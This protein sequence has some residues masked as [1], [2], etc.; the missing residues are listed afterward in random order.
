LRAAL[1]QG[2]V[3]PDELSKMDVPERVV[4]LGRTLS[5]FRALLDSA[6]LV[7]PQRAVRIA[8]QHHTVELPEELEFEG[9]LDWSP[10]RLHLAQALCARTRVRVLLPWSQAR[11]ELNA[12]LEPAFRALE[13][14]GAGPAPEVQL[15]DPAAGPLAPFVRQLFAD[16][17][18]P[19]EADVA[20][21]SCASPAAQAREVARRCAT[22]LS[23]G[24]APDSIAV[25]ARS[26]GEGVAEEIQAALDRASIAWRERRGRPALPAPPVQ[27]ALSLSRLLEEDFPREPLIE[28]LSSRQL[29]LRQDGEVLPPQALARRL[30]EAHCRDDEGGGGYAARLRRLRDRLQVKERRCEDIA[31]VTTRVERLIAQVRALPERATCKEHGAALLSLLGRCNLEP[32]L[33]AEEPADGGPALTRA[34]L[35]ALARDQAAFQ[36]LEECCV[37]VARAA[38]QLASSEKRIARAEWTQLLT[39]ILSDA[40]LAPGGARGGAVQLVELRELAGRS[41][42]HVL[43]VGLVDGDLPQ[44]AAADPLLSDD[45]KRAVNRAARRLVFRDRQAEEPLLFQLGLCA[46]HSSA[47]LLWPRADVQ[48]REL[49]RSPFVDEAARALGR[50]AEGVALSAIAEANA[51]AGATDLLARTALDAFADPAYRVTPPGPAADARMLAAAVAASPLAPRLRRIARGAAAERERVLVFTGEIPP[52]RFSGQ[53][54]GAALEAALPRFAF[55]AERPL[56][57]RQ[58][59]AHAICGFRTL[60][61]RLLHL[62]SEDEDD[63]ELGRRERGVLLHQCL[64]KFFRR[65]IDERRA[66]DDVELLREVAR[67]EIASFAEREHVGHTALW[68]LKWPVLI[69]ELVGVVEEQPA[70]PIAV[71]QSFGYPEGWPTLQVGD[72]HFRGKIDRIDRLADGALL[73][74]DYKSGS[75][76]PLRRKLKEALAPE[77]QLALYAAAVRQQHP[78]ARVAARYLSIRDADVTPDFPDVQEALPGAVHEH[79]ARMRAG[80]FPVKP[81]NCDHCDLKPACR[82]VALPTDPDEEPARA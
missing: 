12:A 55:G 29:W 44:R 26:L 70:S 43:I 16:N 30:R 7:E 79:V 66:P 6:G 82:L 48:G 57:A 58:L 67:A 53:L 23:A 80:T 38:A 76:A 15:V 14:L 41:F 19:A 35:S 33:R 17:A 39:E 24:A 71:E 52:G 64:E 20:L 37:A 73:V 13:S 3:D 11:P 1:G 68:D 36:R 47:V 77:F 25:A 40:S 69:E 49:V 8:V 46:A 72:V 63:D 56:S 61:Q 60:G 34:V 27:L 31:E 51:C 32:R 45:E 18:E 50:S 62:S 21:V 75:I 5:G 22:L 42:D 10:L 59:E 74:L 4:A 2:L 28:L 81:L 65:V 9:I 54:S 78:D